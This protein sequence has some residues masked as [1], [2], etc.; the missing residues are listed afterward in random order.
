M[1]E[2]STVITY[3][4][5]LLTADTDVNIVTHGLS[6]SIDLD[7]TTN[8]PLAHIQIT[9]SEIAEGFVSFTFEIHALKP[10]VTTGNVSVDKWIKNDNEIANLDSCFDIV[11]RL[12][13]G[14]RLKSNEFDI[15]LTG[16]SNPEPIT[17]DFMN[18]LDGWK[19]T[20]QLQITNNISVC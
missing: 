5:D 14:L 4:K 12:V 1:S 11:N 10:R 20:L 2:F 8:F 19:V 7:K 16:S 3:L 18:L 15:E 6:D 9:A 17:M 13:L